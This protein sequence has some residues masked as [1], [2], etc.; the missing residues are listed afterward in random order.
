M[1]FSNKRA[2]AVTAALTLLAAAAAPAL[3]GSRAQLRF[4]SF[5]IRDQAPAPEEAKAYRSGA[6]GLAELVDQWLASP[7]HDNRIRR[8]FRDM[9]GVATGLQPMDDAFVL[10]LSASGFLFRTGTPNVC[11]PGEEVSSEAWWLE[12]GETVLV[13]PQEVTATLDYETDD[14][15]R[16]ACTSDKI[17]REK[18]GCGPRLIGCLPA[19]L[20]DTLASQ[21]RA[22]FPERALRAYQSDATWLDTFAGEIFYGTRLL[23][24]TYLHTAKMARGGLL[25]TAAE[26]AT[27]QSLPMDAWTQAPYPEGAERAGLLTSPGFL[28]QHNNYRT[29]VRALSEKLLCQPIGPALN[30]SGIEVFLNPDFS[31]EDLKHAGPTDCARC[32]YPM[33][34]LGSLLFGWNTMGQWNPRGKPPSQIGHAFGQDGVGP[35]FAIRS[36]I[37]R[38]PGFLECMASSA[39]EEFSGS[40]WSELTGTDRRALL[41]LAIGGPRSLIQTMLRSTLL[42][43]LGVDTPEEQER[44]K[45]KVSWAEVAPV[46]R[47]S[48]GG[49]SCHSVGT[50][51]T[52]YVDNEKNVVRNAA[53][54]A[55]RITATDGRIMPPKTSDLSLTDEQRSL[56]LS[57]VQP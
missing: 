43:N 47:D 53:A 23:Y 21:V 54:I 7:A 10:E 2:L 45:P 44:P 30:T 14:G 36:I 28:L 17:G 16:A 40:A 48:C 25:P 9:F 56:L 38:G 49:S 29:R 33:D 46:L 27:L 52:T 41:T 19:G 37:E 12:P 50:F 24:W 35:R 11:Q 20:V 3:A 51:N 1:V 15:R 31:P 22:E 13:C 32:H 5:T 42:A 39:W 26:L 18:C 55:A 6:I 34:N 4:L 8:Y 57:F